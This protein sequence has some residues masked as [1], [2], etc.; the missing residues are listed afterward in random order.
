ME[1][2]RLYKTFEKE[3]NKYAIFSNSFLEE[4]AKM[5]SCEIIVQKQK[6][7]I[8]CKYLF[9]FLGIKKAPTLFGAFLNM[10]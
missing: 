3:I 2:D 6:K 10:C 1:D 5:S 9:W 4:I 7:N 8:S